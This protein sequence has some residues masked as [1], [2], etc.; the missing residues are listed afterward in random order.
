MEYLAKLPE[1]LATRC[2]SLSAQNR[3]AAVLFC[4]A[5][6]VGVVFFANGT[7]GEKC[8]PLFDGRTFSFEEL[9]EM[10]RAF[11][12][13]GLLDSQIVANQIHVPSAEKDAYLVALQS[14]DALP[15]A[16]DESVDQAVANSHFF[17]TA[18]ETEMSYRHAEQKKLARIV[19]SLNGIESASVQYDEVKKPG[20]PPSVEVWAL[21]AVR[22]V[23]GRE[24]DFEQIE[25]IRDTVAGYVAGLDR[26]HVTVTDLVAGRAYPGS[27]DRDGALGASHAYALAKRIMESE[28]RQKIQRRLEMY[29]GVVVGVD[30]QLTRPAPLQ[31]PP[32]ADSSESENLLVPSLVT[33]SIGL[34]KSYF[35]KIWR[36]SPGTSGRSVPEKTELQ[37]IEQE[38]Q[39]EVQ[40][41]VLAMLPPLPPDMQTRQQVTV[42]SYMD[43]QSPAATQLAANS[44][45]EGLLAGNKFVTALGLLVLVGGVLGIGWKYRTVWIGQPARAASAGAN[46]SLPD[47]G[48]FV[49]SQIPG[50]Q[51]AA[52]DM[53]DEITRIVRQNP[54]AAAE[55]LRKWLDNAA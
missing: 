23:G 24:L 27:Y 14:T 40:Q 32:A 4:L 43:A 9:A 20:F 42:T 50:D 1:Q 45:D 11:R 47:S 26:S 21:A 34:P 12:D 19:G 10:T 39:A 49:T 15:P 35:E 55:L 38:V 17:A 2:R 16:F 5:I 41:A 53:H 25:T 46:T 44:T 18:Q 33:V 22:A 31:Q 54:E 51:H 36:D 30:V 6:L 3:I 28:F 37:Q 29:P 7:S 52:E 13:A 8:E 48:E